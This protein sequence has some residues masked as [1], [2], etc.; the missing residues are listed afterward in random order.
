[1][2]LCETA[3]G[4]TRRVPGVDRESAVARTAVTSHP[5]KR[6]LARARAMGWEIEIGID[7]RGEDPGG[8]S[9]RPGENPIGPHWS[10]KV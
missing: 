8:R 6:S 2:S 7:P 9:S 4:L 5:A 3:A 1:M 10:L